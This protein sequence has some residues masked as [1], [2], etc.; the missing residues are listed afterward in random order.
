MMRRSKDRR[1]GVSLVELLVVIF[2][3]T[4]IFGIVASLTSAM[5]ETQAASR[6]QFRGQAGLTSLAD[7]FRDDV[8]AAAGFRP[9]AAEGEKLGPGWEIRLGPNHRIEYR[10]GEKGV[11]R[12]EHEGEKLLREEEYYLPRGS[13]A[14]AAAAGEKGREV[15]TLRLAFAESESPR[16][17]LRIDAA[18][19]LHR[20]EG[21]SP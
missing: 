11:V 14:S 19:G 1:R 13:V 8:H 20:G 18:L 10:Q 16:P 9:L 2:I 4:V 6:D 5:I 3:S 12:S 21:P 17:P 15:V 7:Q